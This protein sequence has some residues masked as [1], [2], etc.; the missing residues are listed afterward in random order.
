MKTALI[1]LAVV[2]LLMAAAQAGPIAVGREGGIT[3]TLTDEPCA[4]TAIANLPGRITWEEHGRIVEGC[5]TVT[6]PMIVAYFADRT[7]V[8]MPAQLFTKVRA[9]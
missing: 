9:I 7:V 1:V 8:L 2:L 6:G 3:V 4:V 5:Y